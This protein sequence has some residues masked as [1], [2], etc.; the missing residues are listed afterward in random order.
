MF[1][2]IS[3]CTVPDAAA[4]AAMPCSAPTPMDR[5]VVILLADW[6]TVACPAAGGRVL[7]YEIRHSKEYAI[8]LVLIACDQPPSVTEGWNGV[9]HA[10]PEEP[11][12]VYMARDTAWEPGSLAKVAQQLWPLM[13]KKEADVGL[14]GYSNL[15]P[16]PAKIAKFN[17]FILTR[18]L[19]K[20]WALAALSA[21]TSRSMLQ[22]ACQASAWGGCELWGLKPAALLCTCRQ[23]PPGS[24]PSCI[25][26]VAMHT[27]VTV[28]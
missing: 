15:D 19:V 26:Y 24:L 7:R 13:E 21:L 23:T 11:W 25:P 3:C 1:T 6:S 22:H 18:A 14:V 9:F 8:N 12:G 17:V 20:R 10:L 27:I 4:A 5:S 28:P 2:Q 16:W